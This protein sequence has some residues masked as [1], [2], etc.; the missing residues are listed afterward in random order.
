[1]NKRKKDF[2]GYPAVPVPLRRMILV[3]YDL[4]PC[5]LVHQAHRLPDGSYRWVS[6]WDAG[7]QNLGV[8]DKDH[9]EGILAV[10]PLEEGKLLHEALKALEVRYRTAEE[11]LNKG[12]I[13]LRETLL[14]EHGIRVNPKK[15]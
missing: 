2:S 3:R 12:F 6:N 10:L 15:R 1:M 9:K 14:D 7:H 5:M 11:A 8:W 4:F 13:E